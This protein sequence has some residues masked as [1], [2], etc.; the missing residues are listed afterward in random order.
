MR[1]ATGGR[2]EW[3]ISGRGGHARCEGQGIP[4]LE[5]V[6]DKPP[7]SFTTWIDKGERFFSS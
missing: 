7:L 5:T 3:A 6:D 1:E 4:F 2:D